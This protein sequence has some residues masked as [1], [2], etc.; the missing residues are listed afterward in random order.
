MTFFP[1]VSVSF[2]PYIPPLRE[3]YSVGSHTGLSPAR[4]LTESQRSTW[5]TECASIHPGENL[6]QLEP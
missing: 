6:Y 1:R 3:Q 5:P 4:A 2:V